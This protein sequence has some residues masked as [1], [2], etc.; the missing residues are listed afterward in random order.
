MGFHEFS[1]KAEALKP[2]IDGAF[3]AL[4]APVSVAAV[5]SHRDGRAG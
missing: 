3:R 1:R 5:A 2:P 4:A